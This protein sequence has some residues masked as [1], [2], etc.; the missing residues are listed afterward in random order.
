MVLC[1]SRDNSEIITHKITR[2]QSRA[3]C[4]ENWCQ[5]T[6]LIW[7]GEQGIALSSIQMTYLYIFLITIEN[8]GRKEPK[9]LF[10]SR[11]FTSHI[12]FPPK[13]RISL[14]FLS[15]VLLFDIWCYYYTFFKTTIFYRVHTEKN[16][17]QDFKERWVCQQSQQKDKI[18]KRWKRHKCPSMDGCISETQ[19]VQ[20]KVPGLK[21]K[22][23]PGHPVQS[24]GWPLILYWV[25]WAS[26]LKKKKHH[27]YKVVGVFQMWDRK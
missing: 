24:C 1:I 22:G 5:I 21:R 7:S 4:G 11:P 2:R 13:W 18:A 16:W 12:V 15:A 9:V 3:A 19:Y 20:E 17:K 8:S 10:S 26:H 27:V 14:F 6:L 25:K 23:Q